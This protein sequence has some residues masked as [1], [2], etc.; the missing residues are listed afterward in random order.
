MSMAMSCPQCRAALKLPD[1]LPADRVV[2]CPNCHLKFVPPDAAAPAPEKGTGPLN[3]KGPV[4]FSGAGTAIVVTLMALVLG[5]GGGV[6]IWNAFANRAANQPTLAQTP[7]DKPAVNPELPKDNAQPKSGGPTAEP[8]SSAAPTPKG[9]PAVSVLPGTKDDDLPDQPRP[10]TKKPP[11]KSYAETKRPLIDEP[12]PAPVVA[13]KPPVLVA[14]HPRQKQINEAIDKGV[15][16]LK[17]SQLDTGAWPAKAGFNFLQVNYNVGYA[18]LAG[19]TLLEC[20]V[21]ADDAVVQKAAA[22]VRSTEVDEVHRTYEMACAILFLDR[23]GDPKDKALIQSYALQLVAGQN[24]RAGWGYNCPKLSGGDMQQLLTF[25]EATRLPVADVRTP[26]GKNPTDKLDDPLKGPAEK[27]GVLDPTDPAPTKPVDPA[28]PGAKKSAAKP[29]PTVPPIQSL[30]RNVALIPIVYQYYYPKAQPPPQPLPGGA[31]NLMMNQDD[32]SNSQFALLGLWTARRHGV[33]S[34]RCLVAA[35][36]RYRSAQSAGDGGWGY[37]TRGSFG[38][39]LMTGSTPPMTCVGLLGLAMGHGVSAKPAAK[40]ADDPAI[41]RGLRKLGEHVSAAEM[42]NFYFLWSVERVG[43]LYQLKTLGNTDWYDAGVG[44]LLSSQQPDG[45]WS[46]QGFSGSTTT[47]DTCF[48]L[49]FLKRS[50]LVQ[51]LTERLPFLMS[52]SE[53]GA[54]PNR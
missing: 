33:F 25:L 8:G 5:A 18:S 36:Q 31:V 32:N 46:T 39:D 6:L 38:A 24:T 43:V 53:P 54:R 2:A 11:Q 23:L 51:D 3:A 48:A 42:N 49:L 1:A 22:F 15:A 17:S 9:T 35:A 7:K 19:L 44:M 26:L 12:P 21:P 10:M 45:S 37:L 34:E 14:D 4:P 30:S 29:K 40:L 47:L 13:V 27:G 52:I 41:A 16:H 50:N 20:Q 28:Q